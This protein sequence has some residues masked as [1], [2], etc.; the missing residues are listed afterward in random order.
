MRRWNTESAPECSREVTRAA[1][2]ARNRDI[3]NREIGGAKQLIGLFKSNPTVALVDRL[4]Q[5]FGEESFE[6]PNG[7][8][9]Q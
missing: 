6:L 8:P 9:R 3:G 2:T 1:K 5:M 4:V 7:N